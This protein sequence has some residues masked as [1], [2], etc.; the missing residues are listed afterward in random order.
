[1]SLRVE[2]TKRA[3]RELARLDRAT[4]DRIIAAVD[5]LAGSQRGEVRR[6]KGTSEEVFRLRVGD[7][8]VIF[9]YESEA[10]VLV[11]RVRPRGDA[12]KR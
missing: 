1:V 6:I 3:L 4:Q 8:R 10:T 2:W 9:T 5:E 11:L 12:Y 7:W